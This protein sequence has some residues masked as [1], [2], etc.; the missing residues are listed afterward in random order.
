MPSNAWKK[1]SASASTSLPMTLPIDRRIGWAATL[2]TAEPAAGRHHH[3]LEQRDGRGSGR[4]VRGV[5]EV[6]R[7]ARRRGVDDDEIEALVA[8]QREQP[9]GG[10]VL[11]RAAE[12]AGDVA[13]EGVGRGSARPAA[14]LSRVG[15]DQPVERRR[16]VEHQRPQLAGA[17][18]SAS[19]TGSLVKPTGH[20]QRVGKPLGRV[21]R[22]H[23][24][25]PADARRLQPERRG[26]G[27]LADAAG[28]A[29]DDDVGG[30][31]SARRARSR[32]DR[33]SRGR[34]AR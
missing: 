14:A 18:R 29:A 6:E 34:Q 2:S 4:D 10:H 9:L 17:C 7:V 5:E 26:S 23:D 1:A 25:T 32:R 13:V 8:V 15:R 30:R 12:R 19:W 24:A 22:H 3:Q 31:R 33:P 28:S 16:R 20:T 27:G 21:D 11:L